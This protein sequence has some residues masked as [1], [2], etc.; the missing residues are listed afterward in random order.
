MGAGRQ[1]LYLVGIMYCQIFICMFQITPSPLKNA[2]EYVQVLL[3]EIIHYSSQTVASCS[4]LSS[5]LIKHCDQVKLGE[6]RVYMACTSMLRSS[7]EE[8]SQAMNLGA[9]F[10]LLT[11][12]QAHGQLAFIYNRRPTCTRTAVS[13]SRQCLYLSINTQQA[14]TDRDIGEQDLGNS[15]I[16]AFFSDAMANC[17]N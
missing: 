2:V 15:S 14:F 3:D 5:A 17:Q 11:Y 7:I 16:E 1:V 10:C 12:L 13:H 9:E 6:E 8:G 4:L